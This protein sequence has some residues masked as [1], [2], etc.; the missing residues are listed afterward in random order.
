MKKT[1]KTNTKDDDYPSTTFILP[2]R[3]LVE[4]ENALQVG[5]LGINDA[6]RYLSVSVP[7]VRRQVKEGKLIANRTTRHLLFAVKELNRWI[8]EG[9]VE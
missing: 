4:S 8:K 7:T 1:N 6:A 3:V 5:V 9:Q 2:C